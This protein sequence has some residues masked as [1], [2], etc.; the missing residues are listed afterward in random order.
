[1]H[2]RRSLKRSEGCRKLKGTTFAAYHDN[3][4]QSEQQIES[5]GKHYRV[6]CCDTILDKA[7]HY[8]HHNPNP[9]TTQQE[10]NHYSRQHHGHQTF[11]CVPR[12]QG[13]E[14]EMIMG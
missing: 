4:D 5:N 8:G 13:G 7:K 3:E 12:F 6:T 2:W 1:M 10:R 11:A 14:Q 9:G